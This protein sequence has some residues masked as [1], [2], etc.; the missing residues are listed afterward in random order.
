MQPPLYRIGA[1]VPGC[2]EMVPTAC[3]T[4][5]AAKDTREYTR[6]PPRQRMKA[7][8]KG[9]LFW[10]ACWAFRVHLLS[11]SRRPR[12][13]G[14][15]TAA[16]SRHYTLCTPRWALEISIWLAQMSIILGDVKT[17]RPRPAARCSAI[18]SLCE[19]TT[20]RHKVSEVRTYSR[21]SAALY[22]ACPA[23]GQGPCGGGAHPGAGTCNRRSSAWAQPQSPW[24]R[25]RST[26]RCGRAVTARVPRRQ[27]S[28]RLWVTSTCNAHRASRDAAASRCRLCRRGPQQQVNP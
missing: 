18:W 15:R 1:T 3:E 12:G 27:L 5:W 9:Q 11:S 24:Q 14:C 7:V 13:A 2:A 23:H 17:L 20:T 25:C 26:W 10:G 6:C 8:P 28:G 19:A 21:H 16:A 4:R 22:T